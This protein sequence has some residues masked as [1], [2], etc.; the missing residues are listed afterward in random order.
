MNEE[1]VARDDITE[2]G[3]D[4]DV[5]GKLLAIEEPNPIGE[6]SVSDLK[7]QKDDK[8]HFAAMGACFATPFKSA[9]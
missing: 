1:D 4:H 5:D 2:V 9:K 3:E 6:E 7:K 8:A